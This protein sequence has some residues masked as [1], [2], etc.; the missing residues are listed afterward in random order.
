ML[1]FAS[2]RQ[3]ASGQSTYRPT[4]QAVDE[5]SSQRQVNLALCRSVMHWHPDSDSRG[6]GVPYSH[7]PAAVGGDTS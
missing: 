6:K 2:Q 5:N 3:T 4:A 7:D 1:F